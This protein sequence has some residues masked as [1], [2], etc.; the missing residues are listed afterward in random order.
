MHFFINKSK[1]N[2][3]NCDYYY[4]GITKD[5]LAYIQ[6]CPKCNTD[7]NLKNVKRSMKIIIEEGSH[8]RVQMD[9]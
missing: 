1:E 9:I 7:K 4:E 3:L 5:L 6:N 8:F 2:I